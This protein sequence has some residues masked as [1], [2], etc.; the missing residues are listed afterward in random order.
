MSQDNVNP[1]SKVF[2]HVE[3]QGNEASDNPNFEKI[4]RGQRANQDKIA[5]VQGVDW[6]KNINY[7]AC[8][9]CRGDYVVRDVRKSR[10]CFECSS[11]KSE[12]D[13]VMNG[14]SYNLATPTERLRVVERYNRMGR[15]R[16]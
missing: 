14:K 8:E 13:K 15:K 7:M 6:K 11:I 4:G 16:F 3:G 2:N 1:E 5:G 9:F 12:I 10:L